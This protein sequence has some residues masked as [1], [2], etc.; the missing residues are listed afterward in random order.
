MKKAEVNSKLDK[1]DLDA[2]RKYDVAPKEDGLNGLWKKGDEGAVGPW[3]AQ[4]DVDHFGVGKVTIINDSE[5]KFEY[6]RTTNGEVFDGM[7][8]TRDHTQWY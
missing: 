5:L 4:V 1:I 8:L 7:T 2:K 6:I 3:T